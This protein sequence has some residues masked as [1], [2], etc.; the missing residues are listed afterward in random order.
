VIVF[1]FTVAGLISSFHISSL[2]IKNPPNLTFLTLLS[3]LEIKC[4]V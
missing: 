1:S 4:G 2:L 3:M